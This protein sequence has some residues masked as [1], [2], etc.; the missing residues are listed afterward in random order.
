MSSPPAG[1][2]VAGKHQKRPLG[3]QTAKTSKQTQDKRSEGEGEGKS[4]A[5]HDSR[6]DT[7]AKRRRKGPKPLPTEAVESDDGGGAVTQP[8]AAKPKKAQQHGKAK[9]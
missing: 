8:Q 3:Q 9:P 5:D 2:D 7:K 6:S 1:R 4:E